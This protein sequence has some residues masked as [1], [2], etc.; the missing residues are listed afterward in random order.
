MYNVAPEGA[1]R[2]NARVVPMLGRGRG[3][4]RRLRSAGRPVALTR[5]PAV[6]PGPLVSPSQDEGQPLPLSYS[7]SPMMYTAVQR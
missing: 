7:L 3:W 2:R 6:I 1:Q 5:E 4:A